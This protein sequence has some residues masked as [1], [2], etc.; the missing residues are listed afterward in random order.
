LLALRMR[1]MTAR[2]SIRS[3]WLNPQYWTL[4]RLLTALM[5]IVIFTLAAC[6]NF[7]SDTWWLLRAGQDMWRSGQIATTDSYS[8]TVAGSYWP[9]HEWLSEV[10]FYGLYALGGKALLVGCYAAV[11]TLIWYGVYRLC[12][13]P[14]RVRAMIVLLGT[15]NN[16]S[17]WSVR[18]QLLSLGFFVLVLLLLPQ[19]SR[20]WWYVPLFLLWANVHAGV[21][22]GGIILAVAALVALVGYRAQLLHWTAICLASAAVTALNP[23]GWRLW[24]YTVGSVGSISRKFIFEWRAPSLGDPLSYGFFVLVIVLAI[25]LWRARA[26]WKTQRDWTLIGG[27][28]V[29]TL[30][31]FSS[32]RHAMFLDVLAIPLITR[33]FQ[34]VKPKALVFPGLGRLHQLVALSLALGAVVLVSQVWARRQPVLSAPLLTALRDC[35]GNSFNP[36][37]VGGELI[38]FRPERPVFIDNRQD[39]YSD[40]FFLHS[41]AA[42]DQ[43]RYEDLFD[44]YQVSCALVPRDKPLH[45]ALQ[46][47][48]WSAVYQDAAFVILQR[49]Q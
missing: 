45:T 31:S 13:G 26:T 27:A 30:L 36:Y 47:D 48:G 29:F 32:I 1:F 11:V 35:P 40:D 39:P 21:A 33:Q 24:E 38:W 18:P 43:G 19:R 28:A 10:V 8:F 3:R 2:T 44:Q 49:S 14:P 7:Q 23:L 37:D 42:E 16:A 9:N 25:S 41:A 15:I 17:G 12:D 6:M 34:A 22:S 20:H 46:R 4:D 5:L